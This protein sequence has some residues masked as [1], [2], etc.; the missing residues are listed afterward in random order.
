MKNENKNISCEEVISM[1]FDYLDGALAGKT[2]AEIEKHL[3]DCK[4]CLRKVEFQLE[5]KKR[6]SK[7]RDEITSKD[8]NNK[9]NKLINSF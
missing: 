9:I 5:L 4:G 7:L 1:L 8:L 3:E 2:E 6:F